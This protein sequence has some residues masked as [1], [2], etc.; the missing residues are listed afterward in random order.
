ME[1]KLLTIAIPTYNR[2]NYLKKSLDSICSQLNERVIIVVQDNCSNNYNFYD[3]IDPYVHKYGIIA[4]QNKNN[5]GA[6]ANI[7][8]LF[9]NCTTKWLWV[10]G[11]DDYLKENIINEII[12]ILEKNSETIFVKFNSQ[13]SVKVCGIYKFAEYMKP[14]YTF[15]NCYFISEGIHNMDLTRSSVYYNYKFLSSKISQILRVVFHIIENPKS[16]C[17]F[18]EFSVLKT[19]GTNIQWQ[20]SDLIVPNLYTLDVLRPY[21]KIF[22]DNVL[23]T[24]SYLTMIYIMESNYT[25]YDKIYFFTLLVKKYG[26]INMMRYN[27]KQFLALLLR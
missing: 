5:I 13:K 18:C 3:F 17:Y 9:E 19:H 10:L 6:D 2:S 4:I 23:R 8:K 14:L 11:D 12:E 7:A 27:L 20:H 1:N 15:S 21:K 26:I 16:C 24:I 25:F 22:K